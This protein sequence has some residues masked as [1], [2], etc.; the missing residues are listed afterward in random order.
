[1][2]IRGL[3]NDCRIWPN[4]SPRHTRV[5]LSNAPYS[6]LPQRFPLL[7][8]FGTRKYRP[9]SDEHD[10]IKRQQESI[11]TIRVSSC[12][13]LA[14]RLPASCSSN[15]SPTVHQQ[16]LGL[17]RVVDIAIGRFLSEMFSAEV[18]NGLRPHTLQF[19]PRNFLPPRSPPP[20]EAPLPLE[21]PLGPFLVG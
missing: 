4:L 11:E 16:L 19:F 9:K 10:I 12:L 14:S 13:T 3:E 17:L 6:A 18:S 5:H 2:W 8:L 7:N 21:S 20:E 15:R 1:M